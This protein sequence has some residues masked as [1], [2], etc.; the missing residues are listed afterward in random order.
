MILG[1]IISK[2]RILVNIILRRTMEIRMFTR[3]IC[4]NLVQFSY[5]V[6][7]KNIKR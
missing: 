3:E 4:K 2:K 1:V 5:F 6:Y 7:N